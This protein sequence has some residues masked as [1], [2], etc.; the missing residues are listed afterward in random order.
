M[1]VR[2]RGSILEVEDRPGLH[3]LLGLLFIVVGT[4]FVLGPLGMF[5]DAEKL[6]W[7]LRIP[8]ALLGALSVRIG[9]GQLFASPRSSLVVDRAN[10][11]MRLDRIGIRGRA[12]SEWPIDSVAAIELLERK[13][14]EGDPIFQLRVFRRDAEPVPLSSV[15]SHGRDRLENVARTLAL[16]IDVETVNVR[17]PDHA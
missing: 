9:L 17:G 3:W 11:Q 15:W 5:S 14:D 13:D 4:V 12:S 2:D 1:R 7:W 8:I 16:A 6:R 10:G